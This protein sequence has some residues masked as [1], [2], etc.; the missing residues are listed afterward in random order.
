MNEIRTTANAGFEFRYGTTGGELLGVGGAGQDWRVSTNSSGAVVLRR[1]NGTTVSRSG[2]KPLYVLYGKYSSLLRLP[3]TGFRYGYG[4]LELNAYS[5]GS[6][7]RV[8][9]I[10]TSLTMQQYLYG[11]G[12]VPSSWPTEAL[13]AQAVAGRTY[14]AEKISRLGQNRS[15]CNCAL[16]ATTF[17]QVF[18]GHEKLLGSSGSRWRSAVDDT[19]FVVVTSNGKPIEAYYS[20]SSGGHTEHNEYV[21][22]G[23]PRSYLRGVADPH[24]AVS[25]NHSWTVEFT[26]SQLQSRLN[27]FADTKVGT[28]YSIE[29][30]APY[31]VS[32]RV[33]RVIGPSEGGVL[34]EGSSGVKRVSGD[35]MR[36]VLGLR[37]TLFRIHP[38]AVHPDGTLLKGSGTT[39]W[40]VEN[41]KLRPFTSPRPLATWGRWPEVLRVPNAWLLQYPSDRWGFRDGTLIRTPNGTVWI[42]SDGDRRGFSSAAVF[43]GLGYD[44]DDIVNV[45]WTEAEIHDVGAAVSSTSEH[46]NGT[47][48]RAE[49]T[50]TVW[51][52]DNGRKR[53]IPSG[54]ILESWFDWE[55]IIVLAQSKVDSYPTG[56]TLGFRDGSLIRTGDGTVW[57]ISR[58]RRRGFTSASVFTGLGYLWSGIIDVSSTEAS[59]NPKGS[60]VSSTRRHPSGALIRGSLPFRFVVQGSTRLLVPTDRVFASW[61]YSSAEMARASDTVV[62]SYLPGNPAK[63][64]RD[65]TLI[66]TPDGTVFIISDGRRRGFTSASVFQGLGF[67]WKDIVNVSFAE[68]RLHRLGSP[69]SSTAKH[70]DGALMR[71]HGRPTVWWVVDGKVRAVPS[72]RVFNSWFKWSEVVG[73]SRSQLLKHPKGKNLG[74]RDGTLIRTP[75]GTVWAISNRRRR[76][77]SSAGVFVNL[78]YSW[79]NVAG[80]SWG[81]AALHERG[82]AIR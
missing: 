53:G 18:V 43:E 79:S 61:N 8:R 49:G 69:V 24:D 21:W 62:A 14:A 68:A 46:P 42:I 37:S 73:I 10:I 65:G 13:R 64:F 81:E 19:V 27:A 58:G 38:Q 74:F 45:S 23:T 55:E 28:L 75:D 30:L 47:L 3:Q 12:E 26:H 48:M 57:A 2:S 7:H 67:D 50:P 16:Y 6:G 40:R 60:S 54:K 31:G 32:G 51:W 4:V 59:A 22:G 15:T 9:G 25:P 33:R 5:T 76:G 17:D 56:A 66:R 1:P 34:I 20:S 44:W 70:P 77:F 39:V 35:R 41:G 63:G 11:L 71:V 29:T 82:H 72:L 52:L 36:Q 78:R 80:V